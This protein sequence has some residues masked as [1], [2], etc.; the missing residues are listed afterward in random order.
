MK[1]RKL[2]KDI[3]KWILEAEDDGKH[4]TREFEN[5]ILGSGYDLLHRAVRILKEND[6][7]DTELKRHGK[8]LKNAVD[9]TITI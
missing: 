4:S 1:T 7:A 5:T 2:I 3:E 8:G 6:K 9:K